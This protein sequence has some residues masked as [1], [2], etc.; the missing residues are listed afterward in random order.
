MT[1]WMRGGPT[2][3][4]WHQVDY[5]SRTGV[6]KLACSGQRLT[7]DVHTPVMDHRWR[8]PEHERCRHPQCRAEV[9]P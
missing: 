4:R 2:S 1:G 7:V 5:D 6:T 8:P 3:K 9:Q